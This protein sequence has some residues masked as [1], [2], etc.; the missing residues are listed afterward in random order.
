[1]NKRIF[2]T[3]IFA[4]TVLL[5]VGAIYAS[6]VNVTDTYASNS[7]DDVAIAS[8]NGSDELKASGSVVDSDSSNDVLKSEDSSTLSTNIEDS[9]ALSSDGNDSSAIDVSK[10]IT[11]ND[12][13]KYYKGSTKYTATF[14]DSNGTALAN[15]DVKITVNGHVY[16]KK[17]DSKGV[18]S[19]DVNLKPGTYKVTATNP[20][21]GYSLTNT[22]KILTTIAADDMSK[23]YKDGKKFTATFLKSNG[24]VLAKKT[25]RFKINGKTYKVKTN[26]KGVASLSLRNLKSGTHK[27]ISYNI[28][29]LTKTNKVKVVRSVKTSIRCNDYTFLKKDS[30][31]I[32]VKLLNAFGYA[33]DKG[34]VIKFKV[35]GKTYKSK[36]AS[37]GIAVLKLPSLKVG[38]YTVKYSFAKSGYY[39][40][41]SAS[42][43][44]TIIPSKTPTFTV[45]ST[46][47]FGK[48]AGTQFKI[49]ATS[50]SVPLLKKTITLSVNGT[51]YTKTTDSKGIVSLPINLDI[52]NYTV[53]YS[54]KASSKINAKSGSV[55]ISVVERGGSSVKWTSSTSFDQGTR[56]C[57]ILVLDANNKAV[58]NGIVVLKVNSK[59]YSA[60]TSSN[61]YATISAVFEPG[62]Y[63]VSY[64]FDGDNE[65]APSSGKVDLTVNK[66]KLI[67]INNI[68]SGARALKS[69]YANNNKLPNSVSAGGVTFTVPEFLYL[70]SQAIYQLGNSKTNDIPILTGIGEPSSPSGDNI[71]SRDLMKADYI[72]VAKNSAVYISTNMHAQNYASSAV[73]KIIYS[74]LV[75][76]FSRILTFY[77]DNKNRLPNYCT[78]SYGSSSS[79]QTG[80]G[81]NDKNTISDL[82]AYL[83]ATIN[84]QVGNS[85]IKN[86]AKSVTSGLTSDSAKAKAIFNYVRDSISYSFYYDT[87][88]G[89]VGTYNAKSGNCVDQ[90]HLLVAMYRA[91]GL[92]ARYVHGTCKF[93]SGSTYGHVWVQVLVD[94]KWTVADPTSSR[95]SLGS[96]AN[97]NTKSFSLNN[98]YSSLPF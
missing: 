72:T 8:G 18:A 96:V 36:T 69:Y 49:A 95:N 44:V 35:N 28:D 16:T 15:T 70:M 7:A 85:V 25:V 60:R 38:V 89:A 5:S 57:Q 45:K 41:S 86:I 80:T 1:M 31:K 24:K 2:L 30:K 17:T 22:F 46:T 73:G 26:S 14:L 34:K 4:L 88:H 29:G 75:D 94:N 6:D 76:A 92:A 71:N 79:G 10:T 78:I 82:S 33:P 61:G 13:T 53:S 91:S 54:I 51:Q 90:S 65:N 9:N 40:A 67:S 50:G 84:C 68:I 37:S 12:V 74:E 87:R 64:Y 62:N 39:K 48:D 23:V 20:V 42:S 19:L 58:S 27:I 83:K 81:L 56:S 55:P 98:I 21:T 3:L 52:G 43:K 47:K 32:R 66:V 11:S 59:N 97:W 63:S 93:S 77:G